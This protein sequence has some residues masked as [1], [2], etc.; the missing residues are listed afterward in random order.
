MVSGSSL[1]VESIPL[2]RRLGVQGSA[3]LLMSMCGG[4]GGFS[5]G[6]V[7]RAFGYHVL[8]NFGLIAVGFL[9]VAALAAFRRQGSGVVAA[10]TTGG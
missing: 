9:F 2:E 6:F 1:L 7:K 10:V 8:S 4:I 5:S 3:D